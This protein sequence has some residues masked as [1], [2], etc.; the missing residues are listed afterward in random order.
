MRREGA[1]SDVRTD[2]RADGT[3]TAT[4]RSSRAASSSAVRHG[5]AGST[6]TSTRHVFDSEGHFLTHFNVSGFSA[7][8]TA[9]HPPGAAGADRDRP[10]RPGSHRRRTNNKDPESLGREG[11]VPWLAEQSTAMGAHGRR[12]RPGRGFSARDQR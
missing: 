10:D 4:R 11:E 12:W 8:T 3:P 1:S 2:V 5:F 6:V 9:D 7:E